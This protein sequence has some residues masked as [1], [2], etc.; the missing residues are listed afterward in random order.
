VQIWLQPFQKPLHNKMEELTLV[1]LILTYGAQMA[2]AATPVHVT[3]L[4][5]TVIGL[6]AVT[7]ATLLVVL[8]RE[9]IWGA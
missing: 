3:A 7:V 1:V 2:M 6:N 9:A 5:Y 8:V 4:S